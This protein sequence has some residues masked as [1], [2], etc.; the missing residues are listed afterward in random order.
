GEDDCTA[1]PERAVP[2]HRACEKEAAA[3]EQAGED[4]YRR[5][6]GDENRACAAAGQGALWPFLAILREVGE[7]V[8]QQP[9][10]VEAQAGEDRQERAE[11]ER[12]ARGEKIAGERIAR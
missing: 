5:G 11:L 10:H 2:A 8:V 4:Q 6:Q 1:N 9:R 3:N 7:V 12:A